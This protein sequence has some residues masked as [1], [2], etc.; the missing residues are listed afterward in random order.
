MH[1]PNHAKA[2]CFCHTSR[3]ES[4]CTIAEIPPVVRRLIDKQTKCR[5]LTISKIIW[6]PSPDQKGPA[7]DTIGMRFGSSDHLLGKRVKVSP[8]D[9]PTPEN[10]EPN[11]KAKRAKQV[12]PPS[13]VKYHPKPDP[14]IWTAHKPWKVPGKS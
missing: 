12:E 2:V 11:R 9:N 10:R 3:S 14:E 5:S 4:L 1:D 8:A 13:T 7:E 6:L